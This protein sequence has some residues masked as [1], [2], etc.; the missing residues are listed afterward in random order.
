MQGRPDLL[1]G[2]QDRGVV[3]AAASMLD[4][5]GDELAD[6]EAEIEAALEVLHWQL[7]TVDCC[8]RTADGAGIRLQASCDEQRFAARGPM[9]AIHYTG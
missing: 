1:D 3:S 7:E 6:E 4:R 5:V 2:E 9:L 8:P